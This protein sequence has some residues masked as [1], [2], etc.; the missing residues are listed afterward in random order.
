MPRQS[1]RANQSS[2]RDSGVRDNHRIQSTNVLVGRDVRQTR[3]RAN[4]QPSCRDLNG[5]A[6]PVIDVRHLRPDYHEAEEL[7][8]LH[9][10]ACCHQ[11][12]VFG[13]LFDQA[14]D[15]LRLRHVDRVTAC[16]LDDCR[17]HAL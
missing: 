16:N 13:G 10:S 2:N 3:Q 1:D 12:H 4:F 9:G 15:R 11:L 6:G 5:A 7:A 17:A 14:R 8:A